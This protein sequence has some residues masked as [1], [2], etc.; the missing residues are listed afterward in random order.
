[1]G[2]HQKDVVVNAAPLLVGGELR[3]SVGVIHDVSEIRRL[4]EE[5]A[6]AKEQL[7]RL[8][9]RHTF[10]DIIGDCPPMARAKELALRA[11]RTPAT[12]L[13]LGESG[14]GKE[15]F[16]HAIHHASDRRDAPF[17]RV[18]CAAIPDS[19]IESALFGYEGGAFTGARPQGQRG[20][21]E[22][23]DGG[24]LFLDEVAD[25][26]L[27][28]QAAGA[29]LAYAQATQQGAGSLA[30]VRSLAV[31]HDGEHISLDAAT[32]RN[33]EIVETLRG[34]PVPTLL[35]LLDRC[36]TAA[37]SRLLRQ[38]LTQ[39]L[40]A[41]ETAIAR[42]EAIEALAAAPVVR[43]RL[44]DSLKR[45]VD[46]ERI[47]SRIALRNARPRDLSGLRD[48]L[49]RLPEIRAA[50]GELGAALL[51]DAS[52]A[53]AVDPHWH[54][55][56]ER[57]IAVEPGAVLREGKV[58]AAGYDAELDELRG[59]EENCGAFLVDLEGRERARTG[60][61]SLK[62]EYNRVHGFYIEVTHA[63]VARI[64]DDY[65]RRQTLKNAERYITPELKAFEDKAL[66]AQERALAREKTLY[67]QLL[68]EL[69]TAIPA[70]QR[71]ALALAGLDVL[72]THATQAEAL[73]W[74]RP[75]FRDTP[76]IRIRGGRHPV[77]ETQVETFI[78]N[79]L[80]LDPAR[81]LLIVTGPNMGGK[82]TYM[83]QTA[84][85]ALFASC[86]L[87]VPAKSAEI[88]PLDAIFTRIG[89]ADDLAGGR[90]TF[91]VEMTEAATILHRAT[92]RS[93]VLIDEIGRG[94]STYDGLAL[95]W[96]IARALALANRSLTLF[97]THYFELTALASELDG[98][99]NVHFDA[100][101]HKDGIVFLHEVAEGPA[102]R[103]YGLQVAKLAGVPADAIRQ[104]RSYLARIDRFSVRRDAHGDLFAG[105]AATE[106]ATSSA[107]SPALE[108][109]AALD[110]DALSPR[111]A[112]A[113]LYELKRLLDK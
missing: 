15:M 71:A 3:G 38:W 5:L 73:G 110:P 40:R 111:D 88:G 90:S 70:L 25:A 89:A 52:E 74:S 77:V 47:A 98:C 58:I 46:V 59:I 84:I 83:R 63:H 94:T 93:L 99:A 49:A 86:G 37:G 105:D 102:D 36:A 60:I 26:P 79:D 82:S 56:L 104:A 16:A 11:A 91:M 48:T 57:A 76:G 50:A 97:A 9:S 45:T 65:R 107:V 27:A 6:T 21:F 35:S 41:R 1:V 96:A 22:E 54:G 2:P 108:R 66:S 62:V 12:V 112:H 81:R 14:T 87:F 33:L 61:A 51:G 80:S 78:P 92:S 18:N 101:E 72:G 85:I 44:V 100:V 113:A 69:A 68:A 23:A 64:P 24:S 53:L 32:R 34:E 39:P 19:L 4:S 28:V 7:R 106:P 31:E 30:H 17:I 10:E 29:L 75:N 67:E 95:A 42:H 103:S 8:E 20:H 55:L 43:R 109:L 13:L